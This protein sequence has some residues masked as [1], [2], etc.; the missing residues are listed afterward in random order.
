MQGWMIS[1]KLDSDL[2]LVLVRKE[3][4]LASGPFSVSF[5]AYEQRRRKENIEETCNTVEMVKITPSYDLDLSF[6]I[7]QE[8]NLGRLERLTL[9]QL[10]QCYKEKNSQ[11]S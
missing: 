5:L 10:G 1:V 4:T 2:N 8:W 9:E 7:F 6:S 3:R 11:L